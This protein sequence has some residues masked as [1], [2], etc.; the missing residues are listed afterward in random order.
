MNEV[1]ARLARALNPLL[2]IVIAIGGACAGG[3]I[4]NGPVGAILGGV[5]GTA[6]GLG[7]CGAIAALASIDGKLASA[8]ASA[9]DASASGRLLKP[10]ATAL[11]AYAGGSHAMNGHTHV[12]SVPA[13]A[14]SA[15]ALVSTAPTEAAVSDAN[16][17]SNDTE[18]ELL[19]AGKFAEYHLAKAKRLFAANNFK[20]AAY[21][22]T[23]SLA[24]G[25]LAGAKE[26][27][28]TARAQAK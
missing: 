1:L 8:L 17:E 9:P 22:A 24:H 28:N 26:L 2:G 10:M 4:A 23:A 3:V 16:I 14:N 18:A 13:A 12:A 19:A 20:D 7:I 25:D 15:I 11:P 27:L 21:Q 6:L 5:F